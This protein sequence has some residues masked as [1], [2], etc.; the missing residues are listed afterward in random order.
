[1]LII[2]PI[3]AV[4]KR[5]SLYW[6]SSLPV[7]GVPKKLCPVSV[8]AVEE[9]WIQPSWFSKVAQIRVQLRVWDPI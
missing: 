7:Q 6:V 2:L 3:P 1:M 4:M 8:A 5:D 9:L